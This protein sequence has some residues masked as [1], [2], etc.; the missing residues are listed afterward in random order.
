MGDSANGKNLFVK[1][2]AMCHTITKDG[3]HKVGPNLYG[4][5][6]KTCGTTPGFKYTDSMKSKG[7][8]W[9]EH[10]LD[11]YLEYPMKYIPGTRMVFNGIKK[12]EARKDIIAYLSTLK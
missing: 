2:C 1:M 5:V 3:S 7:I 11:E 9:D 12:P 8:T 6:G 10:T 4:I